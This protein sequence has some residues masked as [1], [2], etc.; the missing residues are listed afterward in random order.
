MFIPGFYR[1]FAASPEG[2]RL[3]AI[4]H[5]CDPASL[6]VP[7]PGYRLWRR[8]CRPWP[9]KNLGFATTTWQ[10]YLGWL[11]GEIVKSR[12]R[13]MV[14]EKMAVPGDISVWG[15]L[16]RRHTRWRRRERPT[17]QSGCRVGFT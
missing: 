16:C 17:G 1:A 7:S 10:K 4:C 8:W 6:N 15:V 11:T 13:V 2:Q 9:A 5:T 12:G 14:K 3:T